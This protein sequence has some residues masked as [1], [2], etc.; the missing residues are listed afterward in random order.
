MK[1]PLKIVVLLLVTLFAITSC[2]KDAANTPEVIVDELL[3]TPVP[4]P[5]GTTGNLK[6]EFKNVVDTEPLVLGTEYTNPSGE[7]FS[8]TKFNYYISNIVLTKSDNSTLKI[9]EVYQIVKQ[10]DE[11]SRVITLQN[12]PIGSYTSIQL[13][14]G[15]DSAKNNS[16]AHTGG[17]D[18]AYAEDMF[19]SWKQGY[20]FLKIEGTSPASIS[21]S[22]SIS[23]HIGGFGGFYKAQRVFNLAF[24]GNTA[25]VTT[26][27]TPT[28][29]LL[30]NVNECFK[31]PNPISFST[32]SQVGA[33]GFKS[34]DFA[35]N[36]ADMISF[37]NIKN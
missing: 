20:I 29:N 11:A 33:I 2:K 25:Q 13:M 34:K 32:L 8:L 26:V 27:V 17:L 19:W 4:T 3:P 1:K 24:I 23:Y 9:K 37:G 16:G 21:S 6:I 14:L 35:D 18:F 28:V 30:V 10:S 15:V 22:G 31:N 12:I 36:Y 5:T 7:K